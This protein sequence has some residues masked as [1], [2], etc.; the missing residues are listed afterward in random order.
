METKQIKITDLNDQPLKDITVKV[1]GILN[2]SEIFKTDANGIAQVTTN[3]LIAPIQ[4]IANNT[5]VKEAVFNFTTLP[6]T[7]KIPKNY[8]SNIPASTQAPTPKN[9]SVETPT[10]TGVL[11]KSVL[12][13]DE[14]GNP[15]PFVN[16]TIGN[17][18]G[19]A[20]ND[21]GYAT[22]EVESFTEQITV[23]FQADAKKYTI[24]TLPETIVFETNSLEAV[25][26]TSKPKTNFL[27]KYGLYAVLGLGLLA[28]F[29]KTEKEPLK[30]TL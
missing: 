2:T 12:V 26:I 7:L 6:G 16:I 19:T 22:V 8:N 27:E 13:V 23:S 14:E 30:V 4:V 29:S 1:V 17:R 11:K 10:I 15:L 25:V 3:R 5:L 9:T 28:V 20:T 18:T 21:N 24:N